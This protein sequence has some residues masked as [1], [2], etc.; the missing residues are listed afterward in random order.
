MPKLYCLKRGSKLPEE[1]LAIAAEDGIKTAALAGV[2]GVEELTLG[3]YNRESKKYEEKR[4]DG[5]MEVTSLLGNVTTKDEA[6]FVHIHGNFGRRDY[7]VVGG[8]VVSAKVFPL[9]EVTVTPT[10]N[11]AVRKFD[12]ELGLSTIFKF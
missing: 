4:F 2:G 6:P 5:F 11:T 1:L 7:G 8:H 10:E 12:E 9:L 3:Y